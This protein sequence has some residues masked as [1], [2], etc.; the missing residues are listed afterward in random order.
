MNIFVVYSSFSQYKFG[1]Q[2]GAGISNYTGKDFSSDNEPKF[3]MTAGLFFE[4][5]INLTLSFGFELNYDKKGT[6]YNFYPHVGTTVSV[7]SR[8]SYLTLPVYTKAYFGKKANYYLYLGVAGSYLK[9]LKSSVITTADGFS[10]PL[11]PFFPY[12]YN[13]LDASVIGGAG[14]NFY[15]II[16]DIR[17]HYGVVNV[18][19][20]HNV[21]SI[22]NTFI[23]TTLGY[24]LYKKKVT[25][26]FNNRAY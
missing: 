13:D 24:T 14:L 1:L 19:G 21:P 15:G 22:R 12:T 20:G 5:E 16:L 10:T 26:C 9:D 4:R 17:Y 25:T 23:S 11:S 8:L 18:Y 3:G 6:F 7:D 2:G